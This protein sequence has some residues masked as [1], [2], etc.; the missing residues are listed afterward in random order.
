MI[1]PLFDG[2]SRSKRL[3]VAAMRDQDSNIFVAQWS[4]IDRTVWTEKMAVGAAARIVA[5]NGC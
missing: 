4:D 3:F 5:Q 2:V 1:P